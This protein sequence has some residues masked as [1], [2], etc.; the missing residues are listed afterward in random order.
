VIGSPG[1]L[2]P[3]SLSQDGTLSMVA[4]L[5]RLKGWVE[6][7][8][9][10][11]L[12]HRAAHAEVS[13][14]APAG[15]EQNYA[16]MSLQQEVA[17]ANRWSANQAAERIQT[18]VIVVG[19]LS[20]TLSL[21]ESGSIT[22]G[23]ARLLADAVDRL[24]DP[25]G[26]LAAKLEERVLKRAASQTYSEFRASI[27][28]GVAALDPRGLEEGF[29]EDLKDRRAFTNQPRT[30]WP[31]SKRSSRPSMRRRSCSPSRPSPT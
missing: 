19:Q 1:L 14:C 22:Y 29:A 9:L 10:R 25:D 20:A 28:R 16:L 4:E 15:E 30:R 13:P 17:C 27:R 6:A 2:D 18:A 31:G 23:H 5:E 24:D 11:H 26:K 3:A 21:L 7:Q 8:Q 12:A